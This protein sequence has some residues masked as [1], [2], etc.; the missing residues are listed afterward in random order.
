MC[1]KTYQSG[2][3]G[4]L[5]LEAGLVRQVVYTKERVKNDALIRKDRKGKCA[6]LCK[7]IHILRRI[8]H[9]SRKLH[10]L[11]PHECIDFY[12]LAT[13]VDR[14]ST[15]RFEGILRFC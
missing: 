5:E 1:K 9:I 13:K 7:K 6:P 10:G 4:A 3:T 12:T 15:W 11:V 8:V 14:I 2:R